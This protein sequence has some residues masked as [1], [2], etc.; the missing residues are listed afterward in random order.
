MRTGK[1]NV[2][3]APALAGLRPLC[4][5]RTRRLQA[6]RFFRCPTESSVCGRDVSGVQVLAQRL[7]RA[8]GFARADLTRGNSA[9]GKVEAA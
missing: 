8:D 7:P 5:T 2:A 1:D 4:E 3:Q 9:G 6:S